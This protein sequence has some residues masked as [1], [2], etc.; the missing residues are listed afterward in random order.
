MPWKIQNSGPGE[1]KAVGTWGDYL[2]LRFTAAASGWD[3]KTFAGD[4]K[5]T[6]STSAALTK[7]HIVDSSTSA[8]LDVTAELRDIEWTPLSPDVTY[9]FDVRSITAPTT[10]LVSGT[11]RGRRPTSIDTTP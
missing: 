10:T 7:F 2:A 4:V 6:T 5:L 3:G 8:A 11:I 9:H 1:I